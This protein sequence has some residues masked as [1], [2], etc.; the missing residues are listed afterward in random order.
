MPDLP[1]E[2]HS[3]NRVDRCDVRFY[4]DEVELLVFFEY[5]IRLQW[6]FHAE[7]IVQISGINGFGSWWQAECVSDE[8]SDFRRLFCQNHSYHYMVICIYNYQ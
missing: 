4:L 3:S 7:R 5:D 6:Q 8:Q 1:Q 2:L